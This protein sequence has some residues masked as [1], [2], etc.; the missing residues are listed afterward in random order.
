[1]YK[2]NKV[3]YSRIRVFRTFEDP[4]NSLN[5]IVFRFTGA[6]CKGLLE[7]GTTNL[8]WIIS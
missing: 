3:H 5:Y 6:F 8:F 2:S 7:K 1:M 4:E